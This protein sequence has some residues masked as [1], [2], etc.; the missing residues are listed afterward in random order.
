MRHNSTLYVYLR[1]PDRNTI[2]QVQI[3]LSRLLYLYRKRT[4]A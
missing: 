1:L 4:I 2:V 3:C